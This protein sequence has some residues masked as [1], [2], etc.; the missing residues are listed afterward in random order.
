MFLPP[1]LSSS[2]NQDLLPAVITCEGEEVAQ[3]YIKFFTSLIKNQNTRRAY[4]RAVG[5]FLSWCEAQDIAL[6]QIQPITIAAYREV[7]SGSAQTVKQHLAAIRLLFDWFVT[8][9]VLPINPAASV[10]GPNY[11]TK[12]GKTPVLSVEDARKLLDSID[13]SHVVGLRDRALIGLMIYS[14]ARV[15]AVIS[16]R[17]EDYYQKDQRWWIRLHEKR[18]KFHELPLHHVAQE[19]LDA[20]INQ[21]GVA[22][23]KKQM[24]F[25]TAKGNS[26]C[27]T[28]NQMNRTDALLMSKRRARDAGLSDSISCH[29]FRATGITLYLRNGGTVEQAQAIAAHDSPQATKVYS[30]TSDAISLTEIERI[31]I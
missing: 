26:R 2:I 3:Y 18:G 25:R 14:F 1:T 15:S 17:V 9:L 22:D 4:A 29:T 21:A 23:N 24:L 5:Q 30:C 11:S 19:Y 7:H 13:I 27:L 31:V 20:Y 12:K 10:K 6:K 8:C 16:M 28:E